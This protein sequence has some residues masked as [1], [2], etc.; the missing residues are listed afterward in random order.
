M[1]L[2]ELAPGIALALITGGV[3]NL[4]YPNEEFA[5]CVS[6]I[7]TILTY[8]ALLGWSEIEEPKEPPIFETQRSGS[9]GDP[10]TGTGGLDCTLVFRTVQGGLWDSPQNWE[11]GRVPTEPSDRIEIR[12]HLIV[13]PREQPLSGHMTLK[14]GASL[15]VMRGERKLGGNIGVPHE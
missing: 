2:K 12:H 5:I 8:R 6:V 13:P 3:L 7:L 14:N 11:G 15:V 9:W 10:G 4:L 1:K